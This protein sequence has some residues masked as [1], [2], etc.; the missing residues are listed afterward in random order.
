MKSAAYVTV[1]VFTRVRFA[2]NQLAVVPDARGLSD[3]EMQQIA[4]EFHY[5]EVTF[6]LPPSNPANTAHVRIFTPTMEVPFAGHPNVGTAF[7]L[8][9]QTEVFGKPP[10]DLL[11]FEEAAGLVEATLIRDDE[12]Q[13]T[14]AGILAPRTL[15]LGVD[16]DRQTIA[17][18]ASIDPAS[19]RTDTHQP[20]IASVGLAFAVAEV[21]S[22]KTLAG[23]CPNTSAFAEAGRRFSNAGDQFSLFLYTRPTA[24]PWQIRARMFAP[25]DNVIEDPATGSASGALAALLVHLHPEPDMDVDILIEQ[26]V[27]MGRRSLIN[28]H[29][30]KSGGIVSSVRISGDCVAIMRGTIEV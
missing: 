16:I 27:E 22:L 7:V 20:V 13:V 25:L 6:V 11:R 10:G 4:T 26:G 30:A 1:D 15:S 3:D 18:C 2:G 28:L 17:A 19:I 8:G 12:G 29:V 14:G 24:T 21:D 9:N 23:A 5:S